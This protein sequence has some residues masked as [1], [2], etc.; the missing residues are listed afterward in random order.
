VHVNGQQ[1]NRIDSLQHKLS[2]KGNAFFVLMIFILVSPLF[3]LL[4]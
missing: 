2:G 3:G 1:M 4:H